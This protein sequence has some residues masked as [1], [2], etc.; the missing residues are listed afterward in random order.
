[1]GERS[2][3]VGNSDRAVAPGGLA[4]LVAEHLRKPTEDRWYKTK[5]AAEYLGVHPDTLRGLAA[6]RR[7][8]FEQEEA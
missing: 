6:Q 7:V 8:R 5:A 4:A 1:M 2:G 3:P